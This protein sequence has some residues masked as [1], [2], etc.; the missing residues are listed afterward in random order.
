MYF[1]GIE[2]AGGG[3]VAAGAASLAVQGSA[4]ARIGRRRFVGSLRILF[5]VVLD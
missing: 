4:S 3:T 5:L 1:F 2:S